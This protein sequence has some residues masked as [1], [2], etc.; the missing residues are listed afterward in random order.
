VTC[1]K[2][3]YGNRVITT[4]SDMPSMGDL[5]MILRNY[6]DA[7]AEYGWGNKEDREATLHWYQPNN[8]LYG[9]AGWYL[10][11]HNEGCCYHDL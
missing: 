8:G 6:E 11:K 4:R 3:E 1:K 9:V 7:R 5:M 10:A 2:E